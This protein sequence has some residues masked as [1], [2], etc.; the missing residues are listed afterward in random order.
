MINTTG[1]S[2]YLAG[3]IGIK[4][5]PVEE[6]ILE[7]ENKVTDESLELPDVDKLVPQ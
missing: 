6:N 1:L 5:A 3:A 2:G 4:W 7:K